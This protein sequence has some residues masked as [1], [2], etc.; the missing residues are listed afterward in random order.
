M[1]VKSAFV[2]LPWVWC[3]FCEQRS[4]ILFIHSF[5]IFTNVHN[6]LWSYQSHTP[7]PTP[8]NNTPTSHSHFH[9]I[10]PCPPNQHKQSSYELRDWGSQ[11]RACTS[12]HQ[13][14]VE[15]FLWDFWM[16]KQVGLWFF[17]LLS[18]SVSSVCL[19]LSAPMYSFLS[20]FTLFY[21]IYS[22]GAYLFSIQ[23]QKGVVLHEKGSS[24][25][26]GGIQG[27]KTV[28]R[29]YYVRKKVYFQ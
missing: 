4:L 12:L 21:F 28:V 25:K 11:R 22:L 9:V 7:H 17:C 16:W 3:P 13:V 20:C 29:V 6:V 23:K 10:F 26:L 19:S 27:R 24:E 1:P 8:P 2:S 18:G 5:R 15:C 14:P